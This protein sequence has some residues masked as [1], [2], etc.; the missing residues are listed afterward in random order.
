MGKL[1]AMPFEVTHF[2]L[3]GIILFPLPQIVCE[4]AHSGYTAASP[5]TIWGRGQGEGA[6][7]ARG[8]FQNAPSSGL[9]ATFSALPGGEGT[10]SRNFKSRISKTHQAPRHLPRHASALPD[11]TKFAPVNQLNVGLNEFHKTGSRTGFYSATASGC[12]LILCLTETQH[13]VV[14]VADSKCIAGT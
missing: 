8:I 9:S 3:V 12:D 2:W 5:Q 11:T 6:F 4:S 14:V 7:F 13:A 10:V 1:R